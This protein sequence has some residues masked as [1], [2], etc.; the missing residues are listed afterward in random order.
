MGKKYNTYTNREVV[1]VGNGV[2]RKGLD[3][4]AWKREYIV[5]V[6]CNN[7]Y[8]DITPDILVSADWKMSAQIMTDL[9]LYP[10]MHIFRDRSFWRVRV[11]RMILVSLKLP[12]WSSGGRALSF[13]C[14]LC[15]PKKV[16]VIGY[17][18]DWTPDGSYNNM[19]AGD[20]GYRETEDSPTCALN[21]ISQFVSVVKDNPDIE[22]VRYIPCDDAVNQELDKLPNLTHQLFK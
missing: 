5:M 10:G 14:S 20:E 3:L 8:H 12:G 4:E 17:D 18:L 9:P 6:G 11:G 2:S 22:F 1:V 21:F 19:Y 7:L 16:H 13:A 15:A